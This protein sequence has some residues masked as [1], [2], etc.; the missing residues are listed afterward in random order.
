M[1]DVPKVASHRA[2]INGGIAFM[3]VISI[4]E[5]MSDHRLGFLIGYLASKLRCFFDPKMV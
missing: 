2:Q 3:S 4:V 5:N 1:N